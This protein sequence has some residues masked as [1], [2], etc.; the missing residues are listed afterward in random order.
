MK[1]KRTKTHEPIKTHRW[2][3]SNDVVAASI[4]CIANHSN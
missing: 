4:I 2:L 3:H 1:N